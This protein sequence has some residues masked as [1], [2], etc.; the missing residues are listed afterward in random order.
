MIFYTCLFLGMVHVQG[1]KIVACSI[2]RGNWLTAIFASL[3]ILLT[4]IFVVHIL[5]TIEQCS[6]DIDVD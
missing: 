6:N 4:D 2:E 3:L 5:F 1:C